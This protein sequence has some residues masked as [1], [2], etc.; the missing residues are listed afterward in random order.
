MPQEIRNR[1]LSALS[2]G[3]RERLMSR[4]T[5]VPLS[6]RQF[7]YRAEETPQYCYFI[8]TGMNSVVAA[9]T[10]GDMAEVGVIGNEGGVGCLHL[11]GPAK[12]T[13]NAFVQLEGTVYRIAFA[14]VR[15]AYRSC[16]EI[17]ERILEFVQ[18]QAICTSQ[19]AA[20]N[21]LHDAEERLARWLLM[22][23][24]RTQSNVLQFTQ[25][26]LAM[27]LGS[28]RTT[29]TLVA[30]ALQR[31]GL[32]EYQRGRVKILDRQSL[33]TAACDCYPI[34]KELNASLYRQAL[35]GETGVGRTV[36]REQ[37][38]SRV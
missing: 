20:C 1:L 10:D 12:V 16:E 11:L 24:D 35:P 38:A 34:L 3:N 36:E 27:M 23:E 26:F 6:L 19:I 13:T 17:R 4:A 9:M 5:L 31:A 28:R 22:S 14:E 33:E 8:E 32:I 30:G 18:Q 7:L 29:V 15:S 21:R 37:R 25:E 2:P